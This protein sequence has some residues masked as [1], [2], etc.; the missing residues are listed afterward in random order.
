MHTTLAALDIRFH[1]SKTR[2]KQNGVPF[3]ITRQDLMDLWVVQKG[4]CYYSNLP[5]TAENSHQCRDPYAVSID[6]I[7]PA[8]GYVKDN[9]ALCC[10]GVNVAKSDFPFEDF[11]R[12]YTHVA[13]NN[14]SLTMQ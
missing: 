14:A 4:L 8:K 12:I 1:R 2:S 9:I 11:I 3:S 13:N 5:M 10:W 7:T 6:R